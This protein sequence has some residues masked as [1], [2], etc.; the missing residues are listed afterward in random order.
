MIYPKTGKQFRF[1][2]EPE[3]CPCCGA[4]LTII[5]LPYAGEHQHP[6]AMACECPDCHW[7]WTKRA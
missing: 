2:H 6:P 4:D 5:V 7:R 1:I 3:R